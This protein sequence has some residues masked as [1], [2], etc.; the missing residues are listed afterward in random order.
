MFALVVR[1][2][3]IDRAAAER[4]D[5]L[6][7]DLLPQIE[8]HEPGT[9]VYTVHTVLDAP[10]SRLFYECYADRAAFEAHEQQPHTRY[11]LD[12]R[13]AC[14]TGDRVEH[15]TPVGSVGGR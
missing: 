5:A 11:F 13:V 10:L 14:C 9:L 3:L 6:V 7:A 15:L 2:D 12:E 1:F 8:A 4:F